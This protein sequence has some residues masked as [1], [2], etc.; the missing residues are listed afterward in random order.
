MEGMKLIIVE[1]LLGQNDYTRGL[2]ILGKEKL[3]E[4]ARRCINID[5]VKECLYDEFKE[6]ERLASHDHALQKLVDYELFYL[7]KKFGYIKN[8]DELI[9]LETDDSL[10][11]Y[12]RFALLE[13][14]HKRDSNINVKHEKEDKHDS[15]INVIHEQEDKSVQMKERVI[16]NS[17]DKLIDINEITTLILVLQNKSI[18]CDGNRSLQMKC[19]RIKN[20]LSSFTKEHINSTIKQLRTRLTKLQKTSKK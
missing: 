4:I 19:K 14:K 2:I 8:V 18:S 12:S 16:I 15:S 5:E 1:D 9:N 11:F 20:Q 10:G 17:I 13:D 7:A 3:E 6:N